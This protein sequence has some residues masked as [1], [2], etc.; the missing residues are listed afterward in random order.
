MYR[1]TTQFRWDIH[2]LGEQV[3]YTVQVGYTQFRGTGT[4]HR[5]GGVY[6][7]KGYRYTTQFRW[8]IHSLGV[9]V[10]NTVQVGYT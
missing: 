6:T 8:G 1:Y 5:S 9:Q 3:H 7:V 2:S 10:H 4:L